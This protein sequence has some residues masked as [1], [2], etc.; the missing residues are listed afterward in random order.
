M[1]PSSFKSI[2]EFANDIIAQEHRLDILI[3]S[4]E[5]GN[6]IFPKNS[7]DGIELSMAVNY[8]GIFLLTNLLIDLFKKTPNSRIIVLTSKLFHFIPFYATDLNPNWS[9]PVY[10]Y[11]KSKAANI[12]FTIEC[13]RRFKEAGMNVT[14]NSGHP[15]IVI[16]AGFWKHATFP[17]SYILDLAKRHMKDPYQGS[18][19]PLFLAI[20]DELDKTSGLYFKDMRPDNIRKSLLDETSA[21]IL[22]EETIKIVGLTEKDPKI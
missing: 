18:Q 12:M 10:M 14:I 20:S 22:W 6:M 3:H 4:A 19:M 9:L 13:A 8:F 2:R 1:D 11:C 21:K 15:G 17:F 16:N 5:H 7:Q